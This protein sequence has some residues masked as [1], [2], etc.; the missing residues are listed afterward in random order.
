MAE[1]GFDLTNFDGVIGFKKV[2][3]ENK[4]S[5][6]AIKK[7]VKSDRDPKKTLYCHYEWKDKDVKLVTGSNPITGVHGLIRGRKKDIG[8]ASYMGIEGKPSAV[9]K[10]AKSIKKH[11]TFIKGENPKER[12][13]I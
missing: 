13:F 12:E 1:Y 11:A 4:L 7:C 8:Y 3:K 2:L 5:G 10:L 9:E 6:K